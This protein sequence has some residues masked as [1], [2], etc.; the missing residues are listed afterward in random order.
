MK[1]LLL[2]FTFCMFIL[3]SCDNDTQEEFI[4]NSQ[5]QIKS[6]AIIL[7]ER[8]PDS[9]LILSKRRVKN[10]KSRVKSGNEPFKNYL[11]KSFKTDAMP[12]TDYENFGWSVIDIENYLKDYPNSYYNVQIGT[13]E[14]NSFAYTS[15]DRY[16]EKSK[17]TKKVKGGF[18]LNLGVFSIGAKKSMERTFSMTAINE[19]NRVFGELHYQ[20]MDSKYWLKNTSNDIKIMKS[21]VS[22]SFTDD[23]YN[24]TPDELFDTYGGFVLCDF[25]VGGTAVAVYSGK[26][27]GSEQSETREKNM[28]TDINASYGKVASG[29][30]GIGKDYSNGKESSNKFTDLRASVKTLGGIGAIINYTDPEKVSSIN[31]NLSSW[32]TS[33]NNENTHSII[34]ISDNGLLPISEFVREYNLKYYLKSFL[35]GKGI[36]GG[37]QFIEPEIIYAYLEN[38]NRDILF[39]KTRF[40]DVIRLHNEKH[41]SKANTESLI[42]TYSSKYKVKITD[43]SPWY[44]YVFV[45]LFPNGTVNDEFDPLAEL[46]INEA[47]NEFNYGA[48]IEINV[49]D[50]MKKIVYEDKTYLISQ[51]AGVKFVYSIHDDY[52]LD[53]YGI[54]EWVN[55]MPPSQ[56]TEIQLDEYTIV[57]L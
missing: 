46:Y 33:L 47:F 45:D 30:F 7:K 4:E 34:D 16:V 54:R 14:S 52:I 24:I 44:N 37:R 8:D 41:I 35:E 17:V 55:N 36:W 15:F 20:Y 25:I 10:L 51:K 3:A 2:F 1:N 40:G 56:L 11:G 12:L 39:L 22:Q 9:P 57:A 26:Y 49:G 53:T 21:Y 42:N 28:E 50:T 48:T 5:D 6:K 43:Y 27:Q 29:N 38:I 19:S 31:I 32:L 23:L 18:S 13:T